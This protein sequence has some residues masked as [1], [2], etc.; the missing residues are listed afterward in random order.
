MLTHAHL[1]Q[2]GGLENHGRLVFPNATAH[3]GEPDATFFL[4]RFNAERARYGLF[5]FEQAAVALKPE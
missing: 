1:D 2:V 3:V 5:F 4:D